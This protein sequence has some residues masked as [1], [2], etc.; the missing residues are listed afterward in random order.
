VATATAPLRSAAVIA[1][2]RIFFM[3][4]SWFGAPWRTRFLCP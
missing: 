3:V 4:V 1:V 2:V